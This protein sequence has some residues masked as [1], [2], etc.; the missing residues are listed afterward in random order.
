MPLLPKYDEEVSVPPE[1][2]QTYL[3]GNRWADYGLFV[4][5]AV[6]FPI[7]RSFL[8]TYAYEVN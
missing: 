1:P 6:A 5:F 8:R 2:E 3:L 4:V 7:L